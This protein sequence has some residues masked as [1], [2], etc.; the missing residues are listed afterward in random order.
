ML[1]LA[2][3]A[4]VNFWGEMGWWVVSGARRGTPSPWL[5]GAA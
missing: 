5:A 4:T 3:D 1:N 2:G